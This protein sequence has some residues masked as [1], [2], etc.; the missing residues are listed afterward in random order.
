MLG[1]CA[2]F[3]S[4]F[5]QSLFVAHAL[6]VI[7]R[8]VCTFYQSFLASYGMGCL[9]IPYFLHPCSLWGW[10]LPDC[11]LLFLQPILLLFLQPCHCFLPYHFVIHAVML[12]GPSLL[13]LFG[14]VT[15]D[16]VQSF[17]PFLLYYLRAPVS[18]LFSLRHPWPICFA[19]ASLALFLT[20]HSHELFNNFFEL[21]R[22]NDLILHHWG[23][24]A[25]HQPL[26]FFACITLGL[27]WPILTFPHHILPMSLL[28]LSFRAS[29]SPF[30]SSRPIC[31][32]YGPV[33]RYSCRLDL[34]VFFYPFTN[35][36][37]LVLLGF[38]LFG[39]PKTTVNNCLTYL[40]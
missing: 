25:C 34:I 19:Q 16:S 1:S 3:T 35:S 15:Y 30:A 5:V 18:H 32:F 9:L 21:P 31:L 8:P 40:A 27:L 17:G 37:L 38:F 6:V 26:T 22:A 20:L 33:I 36:F 28:F 29:L 39:F 10:A 24:W 11:G 23:S 13:G 4:I 14:L 12:L 2:C 7:W